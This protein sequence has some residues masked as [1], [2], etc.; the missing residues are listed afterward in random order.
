MSGPVEAI[1]VRL[2]PNVLKNAAAVGVPGT[3]LHGEPVLR[4]AAIAA[5]LGSQLKHWQ[6]G[7]SILEEVDENSLAAAR[8]LGERGA[9]KV[10]CIPAPDPLYIAVTIPGRKSP[11]PALSTLLFPSLPDSA[12]A[13]ISGDYSHITEVR[14]AE[15]VIFSAPRPPAAEG[16]NQFVTIP[17]SDLVDLALSIPPSQLQ[18][19]LA[20]MDTNLAAARVGARASQLKLGPALAALP[21]SGAGR[22]RPGMGSRGRARRA[23]RA[24][25]SRLI[26]ITGS[27]NHGITLFNGMAAAAQTLGSSQ[28]ALARALAVG[29]AVTIVIK[30]PHPAHDGL[31]RLQRGSRYRSGRGGSLFDGR[32]L[33]ADGSCHADC[34]RDPGGDAV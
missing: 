31:L 11:P 10:T 1:H 9:V 14:I 25:P 30:G 15:K 29:A 32:R 33:S 27:G 6:K 16:E 2:S 5:A 12:T 17:L 4:G 34:D 26:A 3:G 23:W 20:A 19:L 24:S 18:F 8:E 21:Q 7:L 28:D 13:I 22:N